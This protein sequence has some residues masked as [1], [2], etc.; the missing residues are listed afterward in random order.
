MDSLHR[1]LLKTVVWRISATFITFITVYAFTG[2]L[3]RATN[4]T[5]AAATLL[6]VGYY[7][8]E[9]FWDRVEWGRSR[10]DSRVA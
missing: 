8:H 10:G 3:S 7:F 2:E 1:S 6:A 4:I 5:L 9:R